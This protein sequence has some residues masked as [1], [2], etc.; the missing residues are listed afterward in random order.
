MSARGFTCA[1]DRIEAAEFEGSAYRFYGETCSRCTRCKA[2]HEAKEGLGVR[3]DPEVGA[4][5]YDQVKLV[6]GA[7]PRVAHVMCRQDI[8][9]L[10][11]G[12]TSRAR[13]HNHNIITIG[14]RHVT[15]YA[16]PFIH[17][18]SDL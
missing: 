14:V 6:C 16:S 17:E 7:E 18:P 12:M 3:Y 9:T 15:M 5:H 1:R 8:G 13:M 4:D 2:I 11:S 10:S